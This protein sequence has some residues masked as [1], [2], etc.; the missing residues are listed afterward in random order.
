M[1]YKVSQYFVYLKTSQFVYME[2]KFNKLSKQ[3]ENTFT[4]KRFDYINM[5]TYW[6]KYYLYTNDELTWSMKN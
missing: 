1:V 3:K 2:K 6:C 4:H 5:Y